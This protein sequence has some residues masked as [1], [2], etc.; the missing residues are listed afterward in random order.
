MAT[1]HPVSP[2]AK[3]VTPKWLPFDQ[4]KADSVIRE[5]RP[6]D[7]AWMV[8]HCNTESQ[9]EQLVND[10]REVTKLS[11]DIFGKCGDRHHRLNPETSN[12]LGKF[13]Y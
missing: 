11:V 9:R 12:D 3:N 1:F 7:I 8:S 10:L 4:E 13:F 5:E 6:K 2:E